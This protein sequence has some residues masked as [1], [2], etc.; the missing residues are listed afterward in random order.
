MNQLGSIH[1]LL[2]KTPRRR[3]AFLGPQRREAL[4]GLDLHAE[5]FVSDAASGVPSRG[6]DAAPLWSRN[7]RWLSFPRQAGLRVSLASGRASESGTGAV[8]AQAV[9]MSLQWLFAR[10]AGPCRVIFVM[11]SSELCATLFSLASLVTWRVRGE[12]KG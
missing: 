9:E 8:R 10:D 6:S 1:G 2:N 7:S 12:R 4:G 3:S 11:L 5:L